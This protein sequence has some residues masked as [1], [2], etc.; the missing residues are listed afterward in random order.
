VLKIIQG[1]VHG[2]TIEL[3]ED[4]GIADGQKVEL[5]LRPLY[6]PAQWGDGIRRSAGGWL[7][8]PQ[9]DAVMEQIQQDRKQERAA[10]SVE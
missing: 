6:E 1:V 9:I 2:K 5:A 3:T 10:A 8:Y 7:N 4:C